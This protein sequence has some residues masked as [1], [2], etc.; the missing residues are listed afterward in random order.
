[1]SFHRV[2]VKYFLEDSSLPDQE[3][4]VEV[5]HRWIQKKIL[6]GLMIDVVDYQHVHQGPAVMLIGHEGD[7]ALDLAGGR[8]GLLYCLKRPKEEE[9]L[10]EGFGAV[11]R[12]ALTGCRALE[13]EPGLG[14]SFRFRMDEAE[15]T[16]H[17]RLQ[18]SNTPETFQ[19]HRPCLEEL[20]A[21]LYPG[22]ETGL[23]R[24]ERDPR[25][26]LMIRLGLQAGSGEVPDLSTLLSR[27]G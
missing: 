19:T 7:Y 12:M 27:L 17:D 18:A 23:T 20:A 22:L 6:P 15:I 11:F 5:F 21:R 1:M 14:E 24:L 26:S 25:E 13:K 3:K 2:S 4:I 16:I 10:T 9:G 8:P